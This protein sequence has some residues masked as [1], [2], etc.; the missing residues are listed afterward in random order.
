MT[1]ACGRNL[2]L[3]LSLKTTSGAQST[4]LLRAPDRLALSQ[5]QEPDGISHRCFKLQNSNPISE[6]SSQ[7]V[8]PPPQSMRNCIANK[9]QGMYWANELVLLCKLSSLQSQAA[10]RK[11]D[12]LIDHLRAS[13]PRVSCLPRFNLS[14]DFHPHFE[15]MYR[16]STNH[17]GAVVADSGC[18]DRWP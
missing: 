13:V 4:A 15:I 3:Q 2:T 18:V 6:G 8:I 12:K 1:R 10:Q 11:R 17:N 14:L 16:V 5:L 7:G 9:P